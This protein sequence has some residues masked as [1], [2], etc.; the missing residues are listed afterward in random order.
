[1]NEVRYQLELADL[2][3]HYLDVQ[4]ELM[5]QDDAAVCLTL[6]AWIPGSYM[7]RDF[8]RHL[9]DI[10]AQD[11]AGPLPLQQTDKQSWQLQHRGSAVT[12]QYRLY[13]FDLS[14]RANYLC[15]DI[16]VIN[17]AASCLQVIGQQHLPHWVQVKRGQAPEHWQLATGLPR[18]IDTA[19]LQFGFY[20][21]ANYAQLID[22]PLLAGKLDVASFVVDN[23][24]H[25]LVLCGAIA[26]DVQRIAADL[27]P[28]CQ[29]QKQVF[30][31][32]PVDLD[33]YWFLT[34]VVDQGY[35]GLEHRNSTLLLC[36][37][38]DL[39]NPR[40]ADEY[41]EDYQNFLALCS[42]EYFHTWWVKRARPTPYLDYQLQAEQY[43]T[44]LW[45]Y[46][47]FTSYYDDLSLLRTGILT[48][49][50][51]LTGLAKTISRLQRAPANQRQSLA[52]SSFNAWTRF[53]RQD[54]NAVNAVVSYYAKGALLAFCLDAEL[55]QLNLC[56][57]GLM[58]L[59]WQQFG[60]NESGSAED[61]F[62]SLLLQ[63][64]QSEALVKKVQHWVQ[65]A[66]ELPLVDAALALGLELSWRQPE[67][68]QDQSGQKV[69]PLAS[70]EPGFHYEVKS[71][72]L[73]LTAVRNDTPAHRAGLSSG[74][75][76]IAVGQLKA[77]EPTFRQLLL[78]AAPGD[79]LC[80]HLFR[81]QRLVQLDLQ[82][83][84]APQTVAVFKVVAQRTSWPG[85]FWSGAVGPVGSENQC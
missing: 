9:L 8:A 31:A 73:L 76:L 39:P 54:E 4:L 84:A 78:R 43:S 7:I 21:A 35:G 79:V 49:E 61:S 19:P 1:M 5:P 52:D 41:T 65:D 22:S 24:P 53:Y 36:N 42:H 44:Q 69:L 6:P 18:A 38:F 85:V 68:H 58:Q 14:V 51:Y 29:A 57:D 48:L 16:A 11:Q 71:D 83:E 72:G 13:A 15:A 63:Y 47:G 33:E 77:T 17:P 75:L 59:C 82:L 67:H 23:V 10:R 62:F 56:L 37:R 3:G 26:T 66:A 2:A 28:L 45:L 64:S 55:Q 25:H 40:L 30:G 50:Q 74:D 27:L 32:L 34:W 70:L 60:Q 80:C 20:R 81:Q 12:V 46:E